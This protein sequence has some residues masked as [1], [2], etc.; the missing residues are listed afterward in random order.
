MSARRLFFKMLAL[1][2]TTVGVLILG[3]VAPAFAGAANPKLASDLAPCASGL[4]A[5]SSDA[6][7]IWAKNIGGA[8]HT[9]VLINA[10]NSDAPLAALRSDVISI[11]PNR[12]A[13]RHASL[14]QA[15]SG[16]DVLA[17]IDCV[18][19]HSRTNNIRVMNLSLGAGSTESFL[20][21]PL[22]RAARSAGSTGVVV[23]AA[24]GNAGNASENTAGPMTYGAISSPGDEPSV[25]TLG[26]SNIF[27][28][29][30]RS[31]D[32]VTTFSSRGPTRGHF[33]FA[34]GE[35]WADNLVKPDLSSA[36]ASGPVK[37]G[38]SLL[39]VGKTAP[40]QVSALSG[41]TVPWRQTIMAD[42]SPLLGGNALFT[43]WQPIYDPGRGWARQVTLR[44]TVS[45]LA[46]DAK[47][48][49]STHPAPSAI[50]ETHAAPQGLVTAG[51]KLLDG[52]AQNASSGSAALITPVA[53]LAARAAPGAGTRLKSGFS[54]GPGTLIGEGKALSQRFILN[55]SPTDLAG[56]TD[57]SFLSD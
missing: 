45:D 42:G 8:T 51:V 3:G 34:S 7:L 36:L 15:A 49:V 44:S 31:D 47:L 21:D 25:I 22:A 43:K 9:N 27:N 10:S 29:A 13:T 24:A 33:T 41:Q 46:A 57:R 53:A 17:G 55:E 12:A 14:L 11:S 26:A 50:I 28:S 52:V 4:S 6:S 32:A 18:I 35:E 16:A 56:V 40:S 20:T 54:I 19:Q 48:G 30:M 39:A 37:A 38:D 5:A 23:V 2:S 1:A